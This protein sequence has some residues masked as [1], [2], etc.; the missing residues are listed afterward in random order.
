MWKLRDLGEGISRTLSLGIS[1]LERTKKDRQSTDP[2]LLPWEETVIVPG[3]LGGAE[4]LQVSALGRSKAA[5]NFWC[6]ITLPCTVPSIG[7]PS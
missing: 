7:K 5:M 2:R 1:P 4:T 3:I 6:S